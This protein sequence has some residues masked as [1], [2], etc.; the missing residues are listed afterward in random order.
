MS[1]RPIQPLSGAG[2]GSELRDRRCRR[3]GRLHVAADLV[4]EEAGTMTV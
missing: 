2:F 3:R 4:G 1:R